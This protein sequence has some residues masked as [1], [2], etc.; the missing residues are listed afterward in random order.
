MKPRL[1]PDFIDSMQVEPQNPLDAVRGMIGRDN[2]GLDDHQADPDGDPLQILCD[3]EELDEQECV[4]CGTHLQ[5]YYANLHILK[6]E[7]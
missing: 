5:L 2:S 1:I 3:C 4:S 7:R 6:S